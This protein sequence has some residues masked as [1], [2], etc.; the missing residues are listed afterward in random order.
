MGAI[1]EEVSSTQLIWL[2][3]W[4]GAFSKK[5][6]QIFPYLPVML[7]KQCLTDRERKILYLSRK[8]S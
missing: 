6:S 3:E 2:R 4:V 5:C 7:Q 8:Q 1:N